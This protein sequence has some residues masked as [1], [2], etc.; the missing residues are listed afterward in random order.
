MWKMLTLGTAL[1]VV[2]ST[3]SA[4]T[5]CETRKKIVEQLAQKYQETS[6][7]IGL[8]NDGKLVEVL[9]N[10]NGGT[11]TII[12]TSPKGVSCLVAAGEAWRSLDTPDGE[13]D[14]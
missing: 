11:W 2:A 7:A 4:A 5:N 9:S 3:A 14:I 1:S 13:P 10:S 8:G 6:V 12:V